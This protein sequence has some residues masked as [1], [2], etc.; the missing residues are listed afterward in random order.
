MFVRVRAAILVP[1]AGG[2]SMCHDAL[3][4]FFA[5][6]GRKAA[7]AA[8]ISVTAMLFASS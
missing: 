4:V 8:P 7:R 1:G 6:F 3:P 2:P 5:Q